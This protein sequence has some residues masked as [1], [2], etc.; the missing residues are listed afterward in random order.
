MNEEPLPDSLLIVKDII[1]SL[2]RQTGGHALTRFTTLQIRSA[3]QE[4]PV[5]S[6]EIEKTLLNLDKRLGTSG[7]IARFFGY[8]GITPNNWQV[9]LSRKKIPPKHFPMIIRLAAEQGKTITES[10]LKD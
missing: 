4:I 6:P 7:R 1:S 2:P 9:W 3:M 10:D 8:L 5:P